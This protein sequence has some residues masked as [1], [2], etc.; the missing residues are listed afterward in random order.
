MVVGSKIVGDGGAALFQRDAGGEDLATLPPCGGD[1]AAA[2]DMRAP[3]GVVGTAVVGGV[4]A[5][6]GVR[7]RN[8]TRCG[9]GSD[10]LLYA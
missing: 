6:F 2:G 4:E 7:K 3:A 8:G 1:G 5:M 10:K 9:G